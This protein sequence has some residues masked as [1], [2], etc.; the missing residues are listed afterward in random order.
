MQSDWDVRA[1]ADVVISVE[2][3]TF[4]YSTYLGV[5]ISDGGGFTGYTPAG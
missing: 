2:G 1:Y 3:N 5:R 4:T